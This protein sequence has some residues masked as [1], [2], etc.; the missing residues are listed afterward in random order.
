MRLIVV[1]NI[2]I[3]ALDLG[4]KAHESLHTDFQALK[5]SMLVQ[6]K[7]SHCNQLVFLSFL[8]DREQVEVSREDL[9]EH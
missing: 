5:D 3:P 7:G 8:P 4:N 2:L 6:N 1:S 9:I